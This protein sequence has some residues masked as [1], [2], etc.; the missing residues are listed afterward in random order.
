MKLL[1]YPRC[2]ND[3]FLQPREVAER[4]ARSKLSVSID[5]EHANACIQ[6]GLERLLLSG[7]ASV[8]ID[9]HKLQFDN[10]PYLRV[11][12][13]SNPDVVYSGMVWFDAP[14]ELC[15]DSDD[16][17]IAS[18][19]S[20]EMRRSLD[21]D[22]ELQA[23][24]VYSLHQAYSLSRIRK[25]LRHC[26]WDHDQR[27]ARTL[28]DVYWFVFRH[29]EEPQSD[30]LGPRGVVWVPGEAPGNSGV[31]ESEAVTADYDLRLPDLARKAF[32]DQTRLTQ[33]IF[34][35]EPESD[36]AF[37][38]G[39]AEFVCLNPGVVPFELIDAQLPKEVWLRFGGFDGWYVQIDASQHIVKANQPQQFALLLSQLEMETGH[40]I[41]A[42][43]EECLLTIHFNAECAWPTLSGW[44]DGNYYQDLELEDIDAAA[45]DAGFECACCGIPVSTQKCR[46]MAHGEAIRMAQ[47]VFQ[48]GSAQPWT[49]NSSSCQMPRPQ[50]LARG[51]RRF[52][53]LSIPGAEKPR[54]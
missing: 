30:F 53:K 12:T 32:D 33:H 43:Y 38:A 10:C 46:T 41:L 36:W 11:S 5:W 1:H 25:Q 8:V 29:R 42:N 24:C 54:S 49:R 39:R 35:C 23:V 9:A 44:I 22:F 19:V 26:T 17:A 34:L 14:I 48:T 4:L 7:A 15:S 52:T 28:D 27:V 3:L 6:A 18:I 2:E 45:G 13:P 37:Y 31:D 16:P 50:T 40:L 20:A 21:Y 51:D 47:D